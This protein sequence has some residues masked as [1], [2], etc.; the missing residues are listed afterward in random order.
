[1]QSQI[2]A[3]EYQ[4]QYQPEIQQ[5][6]NGIKKDLTALSN[7]NEEQFL[8]VLDTLDATRL[9]L[10]AVAEIEYQLAI[11]HAKHTL[12]FTKSQIENDY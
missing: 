3:K 6:I 9:R 11:Q 10:L 7:E 12:D 4:T 5:V 1:M 2:T 8:K